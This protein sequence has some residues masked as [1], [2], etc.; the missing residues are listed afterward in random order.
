MPALDVM[1]PHIEK[2][3]FGFGLVN[4]V[5]ALPQVY[6]VWALGSAGGLSSITLGSALMMALLM[7]TWGALTNSLA[8]WGPSLVWVIINAVLLIGVV[9]LA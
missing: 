5:L 9:R 6:K 1:K 7:T 4:P 2:A 8:L 3:V